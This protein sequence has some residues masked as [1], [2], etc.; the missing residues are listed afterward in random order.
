M[1]ICIAF[2]LSTF[3]LS[4]C[5]PLLIGT[6]A[7]TVAV[8]S[9]Q[10]RGVGQL[11]DDKAVWLKVSK[12][13][14]NRGFGGDLVVS[15]NEGRVLLSGSVTNSMERVA[16]SKL[17]WSQ[18]GVREVINEMQV[19]HREESFAR[20][21]WIAAQVRLA[22][23]LKGSVKSFNYTVEAVDGTI[24]LLGI[25]QSKDE[26]NRIYDIASRVEGVREV[27]SYVRLKNSPVSPI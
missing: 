14:S 4:S 25:A 17:V 5:T 7:A 22:L 8:T 24:Y 1:R 9:I 16:I 23:L 11:I 26:L 6:T 20:S 10:D 19:I 13:I 18:E 3:F 21:A 12:V 27:V 2:F 15:V